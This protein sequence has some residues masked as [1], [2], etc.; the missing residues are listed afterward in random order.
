[1]VVLVVEDLQDLPHLVEL[2]IEGMGLIRQLQH[3]NQRKE[4]MVEVL[5]D[6]HIL[7]LVEEVQDLLAVLL[8]QGQEDL[9]LHRLLLELPRLMLVV[10]GEEDLRMV[11]VVHQLLVVLVV[12]VVVDLVDQFLDLQHQELQI[13]VEEVEVVLI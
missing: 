4:V 6:L 9:D 13:L 8:Q 11:L 5:L 10:E 1:M 12:L 7:V 3:H 2:E